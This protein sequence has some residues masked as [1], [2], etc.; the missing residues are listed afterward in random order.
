MDDTTKKIQPVPDGVPV[1]KEKITADGEAAK[2]LQLQM[3]LKKE[4]RGADLLLILLTLGFIY[5]MAVLFWVLPDSDFSAQENRTLAAAPEISVKNFF[6]GA[7]TEQVS[8]YMAD[9]F[10]FR[11]FFVGVKALSETVQLKGQNNGVILGSD[12]YLITRLDY[13]DEKVLQTNLRAAA[14]FQQTAQERGIQCVAA[15]AGRK[16]D[17]C[18]K[19]LPAA[20]GSYYSD[21]I[22]DIL[23]GIAGEK[24]LEYINLRDPLRRYASDGEAVYYKTDHHWTSLGAYYAYTQ[25]ME[26]MGESPLPLDAFTAETASTDFYGTTWSAAGAKWVKPDT[27]TY[28]HGKDER[29]TMAIE[30]NTRQFEGYAGCVYE[31]RD[32]KNYAVFDSIYV[33]EFLEEKD[34]Y[35]SFLG[36]NFGYTHITANGAEDRE[37][38]LVLKDSFAHSMAPYLLQHYDLI[39]VDLRYY[40]V[41]MLR[42]CEENGID[43]VLMLYNMETLTEGDYLKILGAGLGKET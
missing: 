42:F 19:Y 37:T 43:T 3:N 21:R 39:L 2:Y 18:D 15:F 1:K 33:R 10:P 29:Y 6:S 13:P 9:Q 35:A 24:K 20:Y 31:E 27:V 4:S 14:R 26:A 7:L 34:Q 23:G 5:V 38:L 30:D 40:K 16:Q 41:P 22:W 11:D 12:G 28:Y 36:G 32:G 17:T 25:V 8:D